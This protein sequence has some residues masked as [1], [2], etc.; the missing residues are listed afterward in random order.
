MLSVL[1]FLRLPCRQP[2]EPLTGLTRTAFKPRSVA[3]PPTLHRR[4]EKRR[5]R[6]QH[7]VGV[8][9]T[10]RHLDTPRGEPS[11]E[12]S[13]ATRVRSLH[14]PRDR[15]TGCR[16][17]HPSSLFAPCEDSR[18]HLPCTADR[19]CL[20]QCICPRLRWPALR[21]LLCTS[22]RVRPTS[23]CTSSRPSDST[24]Q[25]ADSSCSNRSGWLRRHTQLLLRHSR[26]GRLASTRRQPKSTAR[27]ATMRL[28]HWGT[29]Q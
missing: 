18:C 20:L 9:S 14:S 3:S 19:P 6:D 27:R 1:R 11:A 12:P 21:A 16:S 2:L 13:D 24:N 23:A 17:D 4:K 25:R 29:E 22:R 8:C 28:Q 10:P 15:I 7:S 5:E 26:L